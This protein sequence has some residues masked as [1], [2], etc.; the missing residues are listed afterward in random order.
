M[1]PQPEEYA[2]IRQVNANRNE[3]DPDRAEAPH[4]RKNECVATA[5]AKARAEKK[6]AA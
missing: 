5:Y 6:N 2:E 3:A 1:R 4:S